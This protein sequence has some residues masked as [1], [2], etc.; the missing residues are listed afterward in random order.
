MATTAEQL[1]EVLVQADVRRIQGVVGDSPSPLVDAVRRSPVDR[2]YVRNQVTGAAAAAAGVP[3]AGVDE[4]GDVRDTL[5]RR[6]QPRVR[7][8]STW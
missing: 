5:A 6:W 3:S 7:T 4:P 1:V 8:V 2:V